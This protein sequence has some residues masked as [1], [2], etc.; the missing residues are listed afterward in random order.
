MVLT[1]IS[2]VLVVAV[3]AEALRRYDRALPRALW[4]VGG[5]VLAASI[6]LVQPTADGSLSVAAGVTLFVIALMLGIACSVA[7]ARV[8]R[9]STDV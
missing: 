1:M 2:V 8:G 6:N 9:A 7:A 5:V 4:I 3:V